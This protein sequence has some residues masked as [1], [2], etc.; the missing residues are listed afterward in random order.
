MDFALGRWLK[1]W[2]KYKCN[3]QEPGYKQVGYLTDSTF[4]IQRK[5]NDNNDW[6]AITTQMDN[7][8]T[9]RITM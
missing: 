1:T 6:T 8:R 4:Y 3:T 5:E 2:L 7:K 9:S